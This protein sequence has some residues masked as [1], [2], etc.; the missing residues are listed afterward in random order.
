M[1]NLQEF[2]LWMILVNVCAITYFV[3]GIY[4]ELKTINKKE[5]DGPTN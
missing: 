4:Y 5:D 2:M 3:I 1:S